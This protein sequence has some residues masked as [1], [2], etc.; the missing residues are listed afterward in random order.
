MFISCVHVGNNLGGF[1][2]EIACN[3]DSEIVNS[4]KGCEG[5]GCTY[6]GTII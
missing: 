4:F 5:S 1:W 2:G 3:K 6:R